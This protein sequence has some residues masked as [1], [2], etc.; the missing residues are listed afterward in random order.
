M[1]TGTANERIASIARQAVAELAPHEL[2][3]FR[4][5]REAYFRNPD[6]LL[7]APRGKEE[8]LGF[9]PTEAGLFLS[10]LV[11]QVTAVLTFSTSVDAGRLQGAAEAVGSLVATSLV[12]EIVRDVFQRAGGVDRL[13][14]IG[15]RV[16]RDQLRQLRQL[17]LALERARDAGMQERQAEKVVDTVA[18]HASASAPRE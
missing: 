1:T 9:G 12:R 6:Q 18:S 5:T 7:A 17:V 2:P 13:Q 14:Q 11:L 3:R 10:P 16:S 4:A 8:M 15:S